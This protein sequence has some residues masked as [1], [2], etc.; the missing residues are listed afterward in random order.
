M[1]KVKVPASFGNSGKTQ[2]GD[3]VL[4]VG[5]PL[6]LSGSATEG[7]ISATGRAVTEP[8][9]L[10]SPGTTLRPGDVIKAAGQPRT[11][12]ATALAQALAAGDPGQ[13]VT[14]TVDRG[15]QALT[16]QVA[17]GELPGG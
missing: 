16:V 9:S 11:P 1:V 4:A 14:V 13:D 10:A 6:G 2:A 12:D 17:L 7:I 5:N 3:V 15:G 8:A